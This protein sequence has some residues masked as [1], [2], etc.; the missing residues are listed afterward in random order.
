MKGRKTDV[1]LKRN[2]SREGVCE[3]KG[4][5]LSSAGSA[6]WQN[7][8]VCGHNAALLLLRGL[9]LGTAVQGS[10]LHLQELQIAFR[11]DKYGSGQQYSTCVYLSVYLSIYLSVCLSVCLS[12]Y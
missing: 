2:T 9:Y 10:M 7:T 1:P 6:S 3:D 4:S 8:W 12:V 11:K 5:V